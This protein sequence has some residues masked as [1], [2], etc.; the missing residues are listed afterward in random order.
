QRRG[1]VVLSTSSRYPCEQL[2]TAALLR[3][4]FRENVLENTSEPVGIGAELAADEETHMLRIRKV[5][6]NSPA[7][8][9]GLTDG[10]IIQRIGEVST[11]NKTVTECANLIRGKAGT[12]VQ[13][14]LINLELHT[15]NTVELTRRKFV[16][17]KQ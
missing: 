14:E 6:P 7:S 3:L 16:V 12:I 11:A 10:L 1:I 2:G 9:A 5:I 13:L 4:P 17:A 8:R 15:T